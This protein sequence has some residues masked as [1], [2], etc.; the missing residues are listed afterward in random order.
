MSKRVGDYFTYPKIFPYGESFG[1]TG[2]KSM[3]LSGFDTCGSSDRL[4]SN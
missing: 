3:A 4:I 2:S 1:L